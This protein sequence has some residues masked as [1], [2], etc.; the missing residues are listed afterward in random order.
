MGWPFT[1]LVIVAALVWV[2][3]RFVF[4]GGAAAPDVGELPGLRA[5]AA[6]ITFKDGRIA[7]VDGRVPRNALHAFADIAARHGLSGEVRVLGRGE[8]RFT[9]DIPDAAQQQLRNAWFAAGSA[10]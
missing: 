3:R 7:D 9:P 8:L 4:S 5:H 6:K 10:R 2:L 1:F